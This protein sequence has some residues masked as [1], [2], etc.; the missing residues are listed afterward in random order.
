MKKTEDIKEGYVYAPWVPRYT[1]TYINNIQVWDYRWWKNILCKINWF[2]HFKQRK[3]F[4]KYANAKVCA[5]FDF[6]KSKF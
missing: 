3:A 4:K 1:S 6:V 5:K 2:F